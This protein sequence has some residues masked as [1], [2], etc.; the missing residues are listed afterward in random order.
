M[1]GQTIDYQKKVIF[2]ENKPTVQKGDKP[3]LTKVSNLTAFNRENDSNLWKID[4]NTFFTG[5]VIK[6]KIDCKD[7]AKTQQ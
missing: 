4:V 6:Y 1:Q 5:P 2:V 7:C 3:D